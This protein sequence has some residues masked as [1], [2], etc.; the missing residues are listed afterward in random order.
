MKINSFVSFFILILMS[1]YGMT[2]TLVP[3]TVLPRNLICIPNTIPPIDLPGTYATCA[4]EVAA[5]K[6]QTNPDQGKTTDQIILD[7]GY[8]LEMYNVT[9]DDGYILLVHRITGGPH[10]PRAYGKP[11]VYLHHGMFGASDNWLFQNGDRNLPFKLADAGYDVWILNVRG[12]TYSLGHTSLNSETD[13]K[14][15]DFCW[16]E[17]G[18]Y[19]IPA[20]LDKIEEITGNEKVYYVGYSMGTTAYFVALSEIPALNDRFIAAFMLS[21]VAFNGHATNPLRLIAP[22][23][24][25]GE[26]YLLDPILRGRIDQQ[27]QLQRLFNVS[28]ADICTPTAMRCGLCANTIFAI[29]NY[30]APQMNYTNLPNIL[31]KFPNSISVKTLVHYTQTM[32]SC[33]FQKFDYGILENLKR[34]K[35]IIPPSYDLSKITAKTYFFHGDYDN[36]AVPEDV[37]YTQSKM[38]NTTVVENIR[39]DWSMFNHLDFQMAKDAD[40]LVY[41]QVLDL[42]QSIPP[43]PPPTSSST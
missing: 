15:W 1:G 7:N 18:I 3:R 25:T 32:N 26:Q 20:V 40:T 36:L 5:A 11:T 10:S 38:L 4:Q 41:N 37:A 22:T 42:I 6:N 34:Y 16:H 9:T 12:T 8:F 39:V 19:D 33:L 30:D 2:L 24:G 31:S 21:P 14:Y 35:N 13:L 29:F 28:I 17:M 27:Y 43:P 23:L